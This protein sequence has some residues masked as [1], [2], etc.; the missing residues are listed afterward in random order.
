MADRNQYYQ[1]SHQR[2]WSGQH[3]YRPAPQASYNPNWQEVVSDQ[4][5]DNRAPPELDRDSAYWSRSS[6][7]DWNDRLDLEYAKTETHDLKAT[8]AALE[9][10]LKNVQELRDADAKDNAREIDRLGIS[11][12]VE[13]M[14]N[15]SWDRALKELN[16]VMGTRRSTLQAK[17]D[18]KSPSAPAIRDAQTK[19]HEVELATAKVLSNLD[20]D[21][22]AIALLQTIEAE[23]HKQD[24]S[25]TQPMTRDAQTQLCMLL[26][27]SQN[28]KHHD[29]ALGILNWAL[30]NAED[31]PDTIR[32]PWIAENRS[33]RARLLLKK[34]QYADAVLDAHKSWQLKL[35]REATEDNRKSIQRDRDAIVLEL[36]QLEQH[37]FA[38]RLIAKTTAADFMVSRPGIDSLARLGRS[39]LF[40]S[41]DR[42]PTLNASQRR[43]LG[44]EVA[45]DLRRMGQHSTAADLLD[46]LPTATNPSQEDVD[47][48]RSQLL[49]KL[50]GYHDHE[51]AAELAAPLVERYGFSPLPDK[52]EVWHVWTLLSAAEKMSKAAQD[53]PNSAE[54]FRALAQRYWQPVYQKARDERLQVPAPAGMR[55]KTLEDMADIGHNLRLRWTKFGQ[56]KPA[57]GTSGNADRA[58]LA[59][60][61]D[62]IAEVEE[63]V[64]KS[65]K[66]EK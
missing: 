22:E 48:F 37:K 53:R 59:H 9:Q 21:R 13:L 5:A 58:A 15:G 57:S 42:C 17:Q 3:V 43:D 35:K 25:F 62:A 11:L 8:I 34:R 55:K 33:R 45:Q 28:G 16:T 31:N 52:D 27:R 23:G 66:K 61:R 41:F 29:E 30:C 2:P 39:E 46:K 12:G 36:Q 6:G 7:A 32:L 38:F 63:W 64:G 65:R 4:L 14:R 20:R 19:V 49:L 51:Q 44:W 40:D 18:E 26:E 47:D 24:P 1:H 50:P 56:P 10:Q 54:V 60:L